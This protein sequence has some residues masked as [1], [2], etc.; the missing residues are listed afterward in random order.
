MN[1]QYLDEYYPETEQDEVST[2]NNIVFKDDILQM[3][4]KDI[5][6]TKLLKRKEEQNLGKQIIEGNHKEALTAKKKLIQSNLRLVVSIAKKYDKIFGS[7][8]KD[9]PCVTITKN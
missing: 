8:P 9:T 6:K 5:G 3:Y 7:H 4:L 2:F 1:I